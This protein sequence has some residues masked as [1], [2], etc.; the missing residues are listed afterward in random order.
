MANSIIDLNGSIEN[1]TLEFLKLLFE[2]ALDGDYGVVEIVT[3]DHLNN[4]K[5]TFYTTIHALIDYSYKMSQICY[6]DVFFGVN[7]RTST[8][9]T[10][11]SIFFVVTFHANLNYGAAAYKS[12]LEALN[13]INKSSLKPSVI[14]DTGSE[15]YC[16]WILRRPLQINIV[17]LDGVENIN[18]RLALEVGG[19][20]DGYD[21]TTIHRLPGTYN[22]HLS[23]SDSARKVTIIR[24]DGPIYKYEKLVK[25]FKSR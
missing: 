14:A 8:R 7:P 18:R 21:I 11:D 3:V 13:S 22:F 10:K 23:R 17:G 1:K 24:A 6:A 16:Y 5:K 20:A 12:H 2:W 15:L 19:N 4:S 25:M 9:G